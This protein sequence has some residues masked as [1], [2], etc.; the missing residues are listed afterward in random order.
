MRKIKAVI[1][2]LDQTLINSIERFYAVFIDTLKH[3]GGSTIGWDV[4]IE[5]YA[6]DALNS[7]IPR[8]IEAK[9]F[10]D[11]FLSHYDECEVKSRVI[12]GA[13]DTLRF[14]KQRGVYV[15]V[16]TGRKTPPRKVKE[17]LE[18]LG[19]GRMVDEVYTAEELDDIAV[20]FSKKPLLVKAMK[21]FKINPDECV[22]VG[23]YKP[24]MRVGK[25]LG[26]YTIGVLTGHET[27]CSLRKA[28]ADIVIDSIKDLPELLKNFL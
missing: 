19:L 16:V 8:G 26:V 1:F 24:D 20:D 22:F 15:I 18:E 2:D 12:E 4:F 17:E 14:L 28:G 25:E 6:K 11:Y 5:S 27:R 21:K 9:E 3:F 7:F 10:W 13:E 23:D